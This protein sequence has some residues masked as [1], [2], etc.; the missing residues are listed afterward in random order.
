MG[1]Q[2]VHLGR[3]PPPKDLLGKSFF[4]LGSLLRS[5]GVALDTLGA[6]VQGPTAVK[7]QRE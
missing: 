2:L 4:A 3:H 7:E 1:Y 5:A 6:A